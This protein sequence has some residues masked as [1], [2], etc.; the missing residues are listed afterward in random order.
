MFP[1]FPTPLNILYSVVSVNLKE[2]WSDYDYEYFGYGDYRGG[3][4]DP[5]Y[6]EYYR[7]E[8]YYFDYPPA[9]PARGRARQPQS[10]GSFD[11]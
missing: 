9:P 1:P 2:R 11:C 6:D 8:D 4:S 5:Y 7:Y 3:Y 10:V